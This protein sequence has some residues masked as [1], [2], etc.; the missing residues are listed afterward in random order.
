VGRGGHPSEGVVVVIWRGA[1]LRALATSALRL[2]L[3][4]NFALARRRPPKC[5]GGRL[6]HKPFLSP[7]ILY[8]LSLD[9]LYTFAHSAGPTNF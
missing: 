2:D 7:D 6:R 5:R 1:H 8:T 9:I 4:L 3:T